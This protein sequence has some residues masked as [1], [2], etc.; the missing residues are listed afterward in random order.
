MAPTYFQKLKSTTNTRLWINNPT[1]REV[2]LALEQGAVS[3]TTNPTYDANQIRRDPDAALALVDACLEANDDE[4]AADI[5][6]QR[7]A[8][9]ILKL[10]EPL[11]EQSGGK[12]GWV[13]IQG[14]PHN[15]KNAAVIKDEALRYRA[16]GPN[17]IAK[18]P[19]IAAGLQAIEQLVAQNVPVF[20]TEVFGLPHTSALPRSPGIVLP[21][22]SHTSLEFSTG[23]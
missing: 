16:L 1:E 17:I 14:D 23:I 13:S 9:G 4:S 7:L 11:Y 12:A 19:A 18:I 15:D 3:C 22:A 20:F 5:V 10:V 21:V 8:A 6:Q 2:E